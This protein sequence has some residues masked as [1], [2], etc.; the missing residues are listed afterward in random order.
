MHFYSSMSRKCLQKVRSLYI[1]DYQSIKAIQK[2]IPTCLDK[3]KK[4]SRHLH[5]NAEAFSS[6]AR[7]LFL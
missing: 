7:R 2:A 1:T 6:I 4:T 3:F 5:E